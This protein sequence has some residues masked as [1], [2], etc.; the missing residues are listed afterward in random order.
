MKLFDTFKFFL[1]WFTYIV[2]YKLYNNRNY[3][4]TIICKLGM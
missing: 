2:I 1:R 3:N 4:D